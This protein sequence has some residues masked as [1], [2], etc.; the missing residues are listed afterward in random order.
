M[1]RRMT[2][3]WGFGSA[4]A[5]SLTAMFATTAVQAAPILIATLDKNEC[6]GAGGFSNCYATQ[7]GTNDDGDKR[8]NSIIKV[9]SDGT[10]DKSTNYPS[11]TGS[12]LDVQLLT[13]NVLQI[14][15]T[16]TSPDPDAHYVA[17]FQAG[18]T[19]LFYDSSAIRE[20]TVDLDAYF[21]SNP[22]YSHVTLFNSAYT[23]PP[24]PGVPTPEPMSLALFGLGL[25]G[26]GL[27]RRRKG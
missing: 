8:S 13:G 4:A 22:G 11:I 27:A 25:A 9:N 24:D 6:A 3:L 23:P 12:E 26:L 17:I 7:T 19:K 2:G 21:P 15:Y 14:T 10:G 18:T 20:W 5:L 16:Q 1:A